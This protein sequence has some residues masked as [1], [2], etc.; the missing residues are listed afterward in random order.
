MNWA[1]LRERLLVDAKTA[2]VPPL[3]LPPLP[4]VATQ[5][6]RL[7]DHP[8][9]TVGKLATILD[10]DT[11]LVIEL[12]RHVNSS[13]TGTRHRVNTSRMAISLLGI[14]RARMFVLTS[15][16]QAAAQQCASPLASPNCFSFAAMQRAF[17]ASRLAERFHLNA[18]LAFAGALLQDFCLPALTKD[19]P[20]RYRRFLAAPAQ[21]KTLA[22]FEY[23]RCGWDHALAGARLMMSW[24]FSDDLICLVRAHHWLSQILASPSLEKSELLP[25]ALAAL[26]PGP[27]DP[28]SGSRDRL[29]QLLAERF[30]INVPE[31]QQCVAQDLMHSG[32]AHEASVAWTSPVEISPV[33]PVGS[34]QVHPPSPRR[35]D[36]RV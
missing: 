14:R 3:A 33:T 23:A 32:L 17:V 30:A 18:P 10:R 27:V 35:T 8:A 21:D 28:D 13:A 15:S 12:L 16:V 31:F 6:C 24:H 9:T 34:P 5:F 19:S 20:D 2:R 25:V 29:E 11:A 4:M 26:L 7:A 36:V 1:A 22:Q